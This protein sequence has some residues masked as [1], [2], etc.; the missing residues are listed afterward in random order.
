M[1]TPKLSW[2]CPRY[3]FVY[4]FWTRITSPLARGVGRGSH[5]V[6]GTVAVASPRIPDKI[7]FV[8]CPCGVTSFSYTATTRARRFTLC[9]PGTSSR[10][11]L[12]TPTAKVAGFPPCFFTIDRFAV[13]KDTR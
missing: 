8:S 11:V 6:K 2:T 13:S 4:A 5:A 12:L 10:M 3:S 7:V 1:R 9:S